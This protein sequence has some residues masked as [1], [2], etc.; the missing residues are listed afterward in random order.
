MLKKN[1]LFCF[2]SLFSVLAFAKSDFNNT[3]FNPKKSF[4]DSIQRA[5]P[6]K[7][8]HLEL[9]SG[10]TSYTIRTT[11]KIDAPEFSW[12]NMERWRILGF[13]PRIR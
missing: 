3:P 12:E 8:L 9:P 13:H 1:I 6:D 5:M 2:W 11:S 7:A 4:V 10:E